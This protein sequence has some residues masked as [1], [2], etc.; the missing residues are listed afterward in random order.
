MVSKIAN[1]LHDAIADENGALNIPMTDRMNLQAW[2]F[3]L[4]PPVVLAAFLILLRPAQWHAVHIVGLVLSI[5]GIGLLI[6][7]RVQLG[8]SF[9]VTPQARAL[10]TSGLYA[11]IR[12]PVYVFGAIGLAG[13]ILYVGKPKLMWL[14]AVLIPMQVVRARAEGK[15]LEE[16]FGEEYRAWKRTTWF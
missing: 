8:H 1:A 10:V 13:G 6:V 2:I 14:L 4:V 12:N 9:S 3:I 5:F 11:R 15:K 7:A 16:S